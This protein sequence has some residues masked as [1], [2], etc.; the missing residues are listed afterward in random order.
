MRNARIDRILALIDSVLETEPSQQV[1]AEAPGRSPAA[2][3][4][5]VLGRPLAARGR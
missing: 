2:G 4:S 5:S 1:G 3:P